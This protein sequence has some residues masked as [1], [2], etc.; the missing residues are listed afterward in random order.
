MKAV[1]I[2]STR[3]H[4]VVD[5]WVFNTL[6]ACKR[7]LITVAGNRFSRYACALAHHECGDMDLVATTF[8]NVAPMRSRVLWFFSRHFIVMLFGLVFCISALAQERV[9]PRSGFSIGLGGSYNS[10]NF[11]TQDVVAIGTSQVFQNGTLVSTGIAAGPGTVDVPSELQF[12]PSVQAG[13][14]RH[15][16]NDPWLWGAKLSYSY[17]DTPSTVEN[18]VI[19]QF[20]SFTELATNK[21]TPFIGA[22]VARSYQTRLKHQLELMPFI[23][24]S[25]EKGF[26]YLGGGPTGSNTQTNIKSLVGFADISGVPTDVSGPPQNFTGSG[27][28]VGGAGTVGGTYF[29]S[30]SWF[31]DIAYTYAR[32]EDQTF[33]YF[34]SYTNTQNPF[35]TTSGTLIGS[36]TGKVSTQGVTVTINMAFHRRP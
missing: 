11:G 8:E 32:T 18:V 36:S 2:S 29:L 33:N 31:L 16:G 21:T 1:V 9:V 17:L 12:A 30:H 26:V 6:L 15:F 19:P 35:G 24:H 28:V 34:S 27:W 22:A 14:F 7:L 20:G 5:S 25:F 4:C 23:G 10:S 13:Y 3:M